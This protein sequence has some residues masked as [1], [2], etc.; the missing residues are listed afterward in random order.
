MSVGP[1]RNLEVVFVCTGNR[2]RSP[3]A[4]ALFR[5]HS[6]G[7]AH[8]S[9][10]GT[11]DAGA[12]PPLQRAIESGLRL[13]VDL[14][15]HR[16]RALRHGDLASADLILGFEPFHVASAVIDGNADSGR[17]F[18]LG[19]FAALLETYAK[20]ISAISARGLIALV[21]S[22]RVRSRPNPS[23]LVV[24][25]PLGKSADVMARTAIEIDRLVRQVVHWLGLMDESRVE[26]SEHT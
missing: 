14:S 8:V 2:A 1:E 17:A 7:A 11:M 3:L 21:D 16:A 23:A 19:E 4:E 20:G 15:G 18:L 10:F 9:S 24:A 5:S 12:V 13:G 6:A 25:D 22:R 26:V